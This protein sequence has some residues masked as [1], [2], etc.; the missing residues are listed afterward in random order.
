MT[1]PDYVATNTWRNGN[2]RARLF[3]TGFETG[4]ERRTH[5]SRQMKLM[6]LAR[7]E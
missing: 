1:C 3:S 7:E 6:K 5:A 2:D 4:H